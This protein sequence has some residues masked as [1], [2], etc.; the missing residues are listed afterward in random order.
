[1]IET[2]DIPRDEPCNLVN[3]KLFL[4][5]QKHYIKNQKSFPSMQWSEANVVQWLDLEDNKYHYEERIEN[6]G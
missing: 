6:I 1:M 2:P 4:Y 3:P 5:F